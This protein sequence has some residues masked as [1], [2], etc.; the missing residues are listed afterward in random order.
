MNTC[1]LCKSPYIVEITDQGERR[2]WL[3]MGCEALM[4]QSSSGGLDPRSV[5]HPMKSIA[6]DR[7]IRESGCTPPQF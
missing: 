6:A 3:C 5:T 7:L 1:P 4:V 2:E